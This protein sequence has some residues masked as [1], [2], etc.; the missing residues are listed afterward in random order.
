MQ[1]WKGQGGTSYCRGLD[2]TALP[3]P[4]TGPHAP[5]RH[6]SR[7]SRRGLCLGLPDHLWSRNPTGGALRR[8]AH[9]V[10]T[11]DEGIPP[12]APGYVTISFLYTPGVAPAFV[13][14]YEFMTFLSETSIRS[15]MVASMRRDKAKQMS[16]SCGGYRNDEERR[17][18]L[19]KIKPEDMILPSTLKADK[20]SYLAQS[21]QIVVEIEPE[22]EDDEFFLALDELG[23]GVCDKCQGAS[24]RGLYVP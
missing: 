24:Q 4:G 14:Y 15:K 7:A 16:F 21:S 9:E 20:V 12:Q 6:P 18:D 8:F 17:Q 23:E 2:Y 11:P 3:S 10:H 1:S 19:L 5:V 22:Y 13:G